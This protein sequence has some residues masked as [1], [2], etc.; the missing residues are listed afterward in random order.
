MS[1]NISRRLS[2]RGF[3]AGSS[4]LGLVAGSTSTPFGGRAYA[5]SAAACQ[6]YWRSLACN[7]EGPLLLP[8][9]T[10]FHRFAEPFNLAFDTPDRQPTAIALC[11]NAGD[12]AAA[13]KWAAAH[14][15][16]PV[17]RSG[18][19]SYAGYSM[20]AGLMI[21]VSLLTT[22][23]WDGTRRQVTVGSG[24]RNADLYNVLRAE[25]RTVTHGRCPSVGVAGFLLG[26]GIGFNMR[27]YG[28]ASDFLKATTIVTA[29]GVPRQV[30][31]TSNEDQ[32]LFW[33]CRG[34]GGGNFGINTSFTLDTVEAP[35]V[36]T[37][38]S[39]QWKAPRDDAKRIAFNV[40]QALDAAD[41]RLGSRFNFFRDESDPRVKEA[42]RQA[43]I[44][45]LGQ[46]HGSRAEAQTAL[47]RLLSLEPKTSKI[48]E[49]SYWDGQA[50]LIDW[51]GP[52]RFT[53]R[54]VFIPQNLDETA[55]NTAF[56]LLWQ[57]KAS[58][59]PNFVADVRFFQTGGAI[60]KPH[61]EDT[62]FVHR[63]SR[64]LMVF[65]L[66]WTA[67]DLKDPNWLPGNRLVQNQLFTKLSKYGAGS[68]QNFIDPA[69]KDWAKA[70]YGINLPRLSRIKRQY[71][72]NNMF[73]FPE[74]IP[75]AA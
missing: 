69:L 67:D 11:A 5:Q 48:K 18:G 61:P 20:G 19:H 39:L 35:R 66:A 4:A 21:D 30:A 36:V 63:D 44:D 56:D 55:V 31:E 1:A 53:E 43:I 34:G 68:Y 64:W 27:D 13:I 41:N 74:S 8:G 42:D 37:V 25:N 3:L 33:A 45:V 54:S 9:D 58:S 15:V 65:G 38:F 47:G 10:R 73:K 6:P 12:V 28:V 26:G 70:Y 60:N 62:A 59:N 71:D 7:L 24:A 32:D 14:D 50:F 52:L 72:P 22:F 46:F 75:P 51:D 40:M 16:N 57:Y 29:D 49:M 23:S 2:R 17:V